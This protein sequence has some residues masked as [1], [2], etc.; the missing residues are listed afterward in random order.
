MEIIISVLVCLIGM[1]CSMLVSGVL[2]FLLNRLLSLGIRVVMLVCL[3]ENMF[4][5]MLCS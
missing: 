1:K 3:S 2:L 5:D 4:I